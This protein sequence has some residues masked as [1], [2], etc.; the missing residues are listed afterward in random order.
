[1]DRRFCFVVLFLAVVSVSLA[2]VAVS[3]PDGATG[4]AGMVAGKVIS[5][6]NDQIRIEVTKIER[7]WEH[8]K[9][10]QPE[11][12]VG[13]QVTVK[14]DPKLYAKKKGYLDRVRQFF[15]LLEAGDVESFDVKHSADDVLTF[16]E[17]TEKQIKR[18]EAAVE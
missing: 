16:L 9:A 4:F 11:A 2:V 7:S 12:L 3:Y 1:M 5:K 8:S 18:V 13:M 6:G 14:L 17:L 15:G 10:E